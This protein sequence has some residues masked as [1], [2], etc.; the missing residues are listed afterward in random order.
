MD[1]YPL[2]VIPTVPMWS[3]NYAY[4]VNDRDSG[5]A[6]VALLGRWTQDPTVWREF[7]VIGLPGDRIV[8]H[9]AFGRGGHPD[10]SRWFVDA[11]QLSQAGCRTSCCL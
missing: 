10:R 8:Y 3:E 9:K 4:M 1:D 7:L 2:A 6:I 11:H 5:L